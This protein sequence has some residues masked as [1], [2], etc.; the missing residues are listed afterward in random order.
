MYARLKGDQRAVEVD[1]VA[2]DQWQWE[3]DKRARIKIGVGPAYVVI[4]SVSS[5]HP[6]ENE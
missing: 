1:G 3:A 4:V 6:K 5:G 2:L